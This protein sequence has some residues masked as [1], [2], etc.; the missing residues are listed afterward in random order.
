[1]KHRQKNLLEFSPH[2]S[3][4]R[5]K[6]NDRRTK[7]TIRLVT[8]TADKIPEALEFIEFRGMVGEGR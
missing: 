2:S 1:M 5:F 7:E 3:L 6:E 8:E 4:S